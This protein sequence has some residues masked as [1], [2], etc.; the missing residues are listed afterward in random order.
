MSYVDYAQQ[1]ADY[2][3]QVAKCYYESRQCAKRADTEYRY[4]KQQRRNAEFFAH[5]RPTYSVD[6]CLTAGV[7]EGVAYSATRLADL[8]LN[9]S[10]LAME[11][12][13]FYADLARKYDELA[14]RSRA[15]V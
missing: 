14:D 11:R 3:R 10:F 13:R 1:A 15:R 4:A 5:F 12:A 7:L 2:R 8:Y 6:G 9:S